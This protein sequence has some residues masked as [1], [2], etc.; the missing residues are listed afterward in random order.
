MQTRLHFEIQPQPDDFTCGPT[1]LQAVYTYYNHPMPLEQVIQEVSKLEE[2]GTLAVLLGCHALRQGFRA[3]LYTYNLQIF[4]PTWFLPGAPPLAEKLAAQAA[5]KEKPKL[6]MA[7]K[8]YLE[9]LRLGGKIR[10]E[11]LT[12]G[13][14]RKYLKR[15]APILTGLSATYLYR[16]A[17]EYG[18][19]SDADD[20]RGTPAGHFVVLSGYDSTTRGVLVADPLMP[21][22]L[23]PGQNYELCVDRVLCSILLG[24]LTYDANLLII[25]NSTKQQRTPRGDSDRRQ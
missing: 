22:P 12:T 15:E 4:D 9:F 8:A 1:C 19:S 10:M 7:T 17:R 2:G 20:V 14:I 24:T 11:D 6:L 18:P 3:R 23:A 13:L 5:C 25:Q 21:N 16:T